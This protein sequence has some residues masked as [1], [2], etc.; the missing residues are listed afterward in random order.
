VRTILIVDDEE[1]VRTILAQLMSDAGYETIE[2]VNGVQALTLVDGERPD[3]IISDIMMPLLSG[4][5]LCH[6]L[7]ARADTQLIPII[8]MSA[9]G[10]KL[11]EETGADAFLLKPFDIDELEA[12]V[13]RLLRSRDPGL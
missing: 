7:K 6:R 4:I 1:P 12:L 5:E 13:E 2:A 11:G 10:R 8:L 9:A 3:L